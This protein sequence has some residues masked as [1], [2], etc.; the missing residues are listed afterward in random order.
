MK[1]IK[2]QRIRFEH[3]D[4]AG[5]VFYPRYFEMLNGLMEDFFR[6]V[7]DYPFENM[8]QDSGI[9]TVDI[10]TQF[11]SPAKLGDTISK[12]MYISK[13]GKTS[14]TYQY[15]FSLGDKT[16]LEGEG[17]IVFVSFEN[18]GIQPKDWD[19]LRSKMEDYLAG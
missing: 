10:K 18:G 6:E 4:P 5:I 13:L 17:T 2:E 14:C 19:K 15:V 1:F 7:L 8:H 11:K 9:P 16:V 12:S 3:C